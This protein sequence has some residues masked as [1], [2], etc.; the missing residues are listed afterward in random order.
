MEIIKLAFLFLRAS[1]LLQRRLKLNIWWKLGQHLSL[2]SKSK[3]KEIQFIGPTM[4]M[5]VGHDIISNGCENGPNKDMVGP[6]PFNNTVGGWVTNSR[7][8]FN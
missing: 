2:Q 6:N 3:G 7:Y 5:K 1:R 8:G 4:P